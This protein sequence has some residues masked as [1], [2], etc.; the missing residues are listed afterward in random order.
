LACFAYLVR[1][2]L[3]FMRNNFKHNFKNSRK[4]ELG[5]ILRKFG[6]TSLFTT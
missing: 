4:E 5:V 2:G 3:G 6:L 1:F